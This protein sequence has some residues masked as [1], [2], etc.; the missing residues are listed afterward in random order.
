VAVIGTDLAGTAEDVLDRMLAAGGELVT[1]VLGA[2]VADD[3][4]ERL[5]ARVRNGHLAV[6]TV[7]FRGEQPSVPLII[8]VE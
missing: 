5:E 4:A 6:D 7:V 3:L 2:G 8:G 1:L